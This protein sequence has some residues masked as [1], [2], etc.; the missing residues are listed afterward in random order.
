MIRINDYP[1]DCALTERLSYNSDVTKF[2][3]GKGANVSDHIIA[4]PP[5]LEIEGVVTDTPIGEIATDPTRAVDVG[6][7]SPSRD[8]YDRFVAIH[9]AKKTV[10]VICSY[11]K[12][13][14]MAL[15]SVES[16][17]ESESQKAF[18]FTAKFEQI[19]IQEVNRITVRAAVPNGT[20]KQN[21]GAH[22]AAVKF[23]KDN[24][25]YVI[26]FPKSQRDSRQ[27]FYG[28]PILTTN[29]SVRYLVNGFDRFKVNYVDHY[30]LGSGD[31]EGDPR[32]TTADGFIGT[33][34]ESD[35]KADENFR[36]G[37]EPG[38]FQES[39]K[40][41]NYFFLNVDSSTFNEVDV[42]S[43]YQ[44]SDKVTRVANGGNKGKSVTQHPPPE[45]KWQ[46]V[47]RGQDQDQ[48]AAQ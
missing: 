29:H 19:N 48:Q 14:N 10:T 33:R 40:M 13:E 21:L 25:S 34:R 12:F 18:K 8:A 36:G 1:I 39:S 11:G 2:P 16:T 30:K 45:S 23:L 22:E 43:Q 7:P 5:T 44:P 46:R 26:S 31:M 6:L 20:R 41:R 42:P 17:K 32:V 4:Y 9:G 28:K 3:V 37:T 24:V 35:G 38:G 27:R 15:E 47:L